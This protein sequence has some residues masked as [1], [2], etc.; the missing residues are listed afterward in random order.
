MT[1]RKQVKKGEKSRPVAFRVATPEAD[2]LVAIACATGLTPGQLAR[3]IIERDVGL[4]A[5]TATVRRRIAHAD[6]LRQSLGELGRVGNN[7]NQLA[8]HQN[9]GKPSPWRK[10]ELDRL[11][12]ELYAALEAVMDA[13]GRGRK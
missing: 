3:R 7:L 5:Q 10:E 12:R 1:D 2:K 6:L 4:M 8:A 13:L 11:L 9:A